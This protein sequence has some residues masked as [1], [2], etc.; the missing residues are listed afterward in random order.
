[1]AYEK[2][3]WQSGDIITAEK[4]NYIENGLETISDN[5]SK[6][7]L[8]V[9]LQEEDQTYTLDKTHTEIYNAIAAGIIPELLVWESG[10]TIPK[11]CVYTEVMSG[12]NMIMFARF[13]PVSSWTDVASFN[14]TLYQIR[15]DNGVNKFTKTSV[16]VS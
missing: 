16:P 4:L 1:M 7:H 13:H 6:T 8:I 11:H 9:N 12:T 10:A 15:S 2:Q 3:T 5:S 14:I